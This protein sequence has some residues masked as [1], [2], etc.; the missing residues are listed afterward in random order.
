M[1][2][3]I[4]K[5]FA[6]MLLIS[7]YSY[8][9]DNLPLP[10]FVSIKSGEVNVRTGPSVRYPIKWVFHAKNEPIEVVAEFEQWRKIKDFTKDEGW[11]HESML[12]GKRYAIIATKEKQIIYKNLE[13]NKHP[14]VI[15]EPGVRARVQ[16]CQL[17]HCRIIVEDH[18]GWIR[19]DKLYGVYKNETYK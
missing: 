5:L 6:F 3:L 10:R 15:I 19:K 1:K 17:E 11:V 16:E 13:D 7:T 18:K 12:S 8:A 4:F 2:W 9:K 14:V